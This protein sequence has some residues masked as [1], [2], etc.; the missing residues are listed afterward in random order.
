[1]NI[2]YNIIAYKRFNVLCNTQYDNLE[3]LFNF[4]KEY[5]DKA[6]GYKITTLIDGTEVS[7]DTIIL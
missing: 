6:D 7:V 4:I 2:T 1:M 3:S 5:E